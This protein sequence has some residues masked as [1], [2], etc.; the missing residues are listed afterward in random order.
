MGVDKTLS[1]KLW[2]RLSSLSLTGWKAGSTEVFGIGSKACS[3][4]MDVLPRVVLSRDERIKRR[5]AD[6][7]IGFFVG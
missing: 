3:V 4:V 6:L 5:V 7:A 2:G 1:R